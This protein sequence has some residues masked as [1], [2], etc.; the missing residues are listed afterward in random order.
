MLLLSATESK[1]RCFEL[2]IKQKLAGAR[3]MTPA[4]SIPTKT[5]GECLYARLLRF[6]FAKKNFTQCACNQS[7][8]KITRKK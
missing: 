8:L 2:K 6:F 4:F 5:L 7:S 3:E 1:G